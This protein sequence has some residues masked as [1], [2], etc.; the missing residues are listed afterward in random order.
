[1]NRT[2]F[3]TDGIRGPYG[4][5]VVNEAFAFR[6]GVAM[7]RYLDTFPPGSRS[8]RT[9]AIGR[10]TRNS[11]KPLSDSLAAGVSFAG[12]F[13]V[14]LGV[15]PTPA[16]A[17][18]VRASSAAL[19]VAITASH[20]PAAD[21]GIKL[22]GPDG[23]KL[24]DAQEAQIESLLPHAP[25]N[26]ANIGRAQSAPTRC[27]PAHD[28]A[29]DYV[30]ATS[31][32]LP[33]GA[34]KGW[35]IVLDTAHGATWNTSACA[36]RALGAE[37]IQIGNTPDGE[38]INVDIGSE[39]PER[40]C[41]EVV[42]QGARLG[43]AHDGDGD[44]CV[45]CDERGVLL[46]GDEILAILATQALARGR[47]AAKTLVATVHSNLGLDAAVIAA[48]GRVVRTAVG[49][50][51]VIEAMRAEGA[52][53]GG[54]SSGHVIFSEI[55]PTGDG[56]VA[57]LKL[58]EV[59]RDTGLPL[60]SLRRRMRKYPRAAASL[61]VREKRPL[62]ELAAL[63]SAIRAVELELGAQGR[64]LVRY[65]GTESKLRL[66]VEGPTETA[67]RAGLDRLVVAARSELHV[68]E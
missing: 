45:A 2:Y 55:S 6:L 57:A 16:I 18:A 59:M 27:G 3:G 43:I 68:A 32:I 4:G 29:A 40:L 12:Y 14:A 30:A 49:D 63:P 33:E 58:I 56:L 20:N 28:F 54:E 67:V 21:N 38:N 61:P 47:L 52:T 9:V 60:S 5:P 17:M 62:G 66:V 51:Y 15:L 8:N 24:T 50:R 41:Q 65:S 7:G 19:G 64:I 36:F 46:D 37:L 39:H 34:L 44:R 42:A 10:D 25:V 26:G 31:G 1:M 48:G 22:F 13:P 53:L 11:G 23:R 35:R